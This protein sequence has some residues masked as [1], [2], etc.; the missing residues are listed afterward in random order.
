[1]GRS[2]K[3]RSLLASV[4]SLVAL[5]GCVEESGEGSVEYVSPEDANFSIEVLDISLPDFQAIP[6]ER[7][8]TIEMEVTN[9]SG[10]AA[11][12]ISLDLDIYVMDDGLLGED[13]DTIYSDW[14]PISD[15][16]DKESEVLTYEFR[17]TTSKGISAKQADCEFE[18]DAKIDYLGGE[19]THKG[20]HSISCDF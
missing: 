3:R 16:D 12:S 19:E 8:V 6:P 7:E 10:E 9:N 4:G 20:E 18:Y 14:E 13:R 15:L 17:A 1:M 5:S 2:Y 11:K